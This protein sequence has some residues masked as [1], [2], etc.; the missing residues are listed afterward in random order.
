[1]GV[2]VRLLFPNRSQSVAS[3][4]WSLV[5]RLCM[6]MENI[7]KKKEQDYTARNDRLGKP[8]F[9][10]P[11]AALP[12]SNSNLLP[13]LFLHRSDLYFT[14]GTTYLYHFSYHSTSQGH[15]YDARSSYKLFLLY[16]TQNN[17]TKEAALVQNKKLESIKF[18]FRMTIYSIMNDTTGSCIYHI[19]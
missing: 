10:T 16:F 3:H 4:E 12:T 11:P 7:G 2:N 9:R 6:G 15:C 18:G 8:D 1:M 19:E 14:T 13:F 5:W 17:H